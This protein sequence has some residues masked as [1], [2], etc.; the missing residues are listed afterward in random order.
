[1]NSNLLQHIRQAV[2]ALHGTIKRSRAQSFIDEQGWVDLLRKVTAAIN[3]ERVSTTGLT[4]NEAMKFYLNPPE[5]APKTLTPAQ[6]AKLE[7]RT[8][9][10]PYRI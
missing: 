9:V 7:K 6:Q 1:M 8:E 3:D 5:E 4:P 10:R 2:Q